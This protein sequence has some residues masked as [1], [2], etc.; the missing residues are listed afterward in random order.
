MIEFTKN[1]INSH[2]KVARSLHSQIEFIIQSSKICINSLKNGGK[3]LLFGNGGSAADAQHIA[4]ELVGR[5]KFK[6]SGLPAIALTTD[7]SAL[8]SIGN[9]FGYEYIFERQVE[10]LAKN[11][12]VVIGISTSG[13]SL[14]VINGL[15]KASE[16][17]CSTI[18]LSG[19][20]TEVMNQYCDVNIAV[21][22]ADTPRIQEMHIVIGHIICQIIDQEFKD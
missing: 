14:N 7:S 20:D 6:R 16:I 17:G 3:V 22:S 5:Y 11:I 8:T 10:A 9:D 19:S 21:A 13:K 2:T 15:I 1:E 18:G 4:A 12:D